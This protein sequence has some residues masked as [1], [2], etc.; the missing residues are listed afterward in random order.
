MVHPN[1]PTANAMTAAEVDWLK[2]LPEDILVVVDEAYFEFSQQ[3]T[4]VEVLQRPNWVVL[5]TFSKAFRLAALRVGYAI[6]NGE[7]ISAL[8]KVRLPYN[9]PSPT[10]VAAKLALAHRK[11]LLA[12]VPE[13][14]VQRQTLIAELSKGGN[15]QLWPSTA[16]FL[17]G[18]PQRPLLPM[19][20]ELKRWFVGLK[21]QGTLIRQTGGGLRITV[22][23]PAE[24]QRTIAHISALPVR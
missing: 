15:L 7:I 21:E 11:E 9:L 22:G 23:S 14:Q 24:N 12:I 6:S 10:Q 5:R 8:E 3:T 13:I 4:A 1:S 18:R 16:N 19:A 2:S 20:E 17:Y